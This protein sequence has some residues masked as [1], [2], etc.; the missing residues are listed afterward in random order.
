MPSRS[1]SPKEIGVRGEA[2]YRE[3]IRPLVEPAETG[4]FVVID[5]DS[6]DYEID[7]EVLAA[8]ARLRERRPGAV[9]YGVRVGHSA[10]YSLG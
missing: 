5:V 2:I 10:A 8:S 1:S 6:G 4:K 3:K 9:S 7:A